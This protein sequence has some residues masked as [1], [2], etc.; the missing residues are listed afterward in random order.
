MYEN[1][2][3]GGESAATVRPGAHPAICGRVVTQ[4]RGPGWLRPAGDIVAIG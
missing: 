4:A 1:A 3:G 2:D